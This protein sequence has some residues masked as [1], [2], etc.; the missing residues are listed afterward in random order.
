MP[1]PLEVA[2]SSIIALIIFSVFVTTNT[3]LLHWIKFWK[4]AK[5]NMPCLNSV[6]TT[7]ITDRDK[8]SIEA[9]DEVLPLAVT[10]FCSYH[11]QKN[12][13][14]YIKGGSGQYSC[15]WMYKLLLNYHMKESITKLKFEHSSFVADNALRYLN[16]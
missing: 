2:E 6:E 7:I 11:R 8:G 16:W 15:M 9:F 12:I 10:F 1:T 3:A 4:F 5:R 13:Q 14:T